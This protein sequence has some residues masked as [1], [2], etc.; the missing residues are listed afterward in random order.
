MYTRRETCLIASIVA[1]GLNATLPACARGQATDD[2]EPPGTLIVPFRF[3]S[4]RASLLVQARVNLR[5]ALL[6]VDTGSSHTI[7]RPSI[8][9]VDARELAQPRIGAGFVGDAVGR[10]VTLGIGQH[11]SHRRVSVMDLSNILSAYEE[12]IDG[13]LGIDFLLDFSRAVIDFKERTI[14]FIP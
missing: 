1:S 5:P 8:A 10:E 3:A 12:R 9:G 13:L 14:A 4:G 6:I 7:L 2:K 11:I